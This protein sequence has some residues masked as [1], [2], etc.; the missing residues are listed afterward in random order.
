VEQNLTWR[1]ED[2]TSHVNYTDPG[3]FRE[4]F[5]FAARRRVKQE[6]QVQFTFTESATIAT[7]AVTYEEA[8]EVCTCAP[9]TAG[10]ALL[11]ILINDH[12][13]ILTGEAVI[14]CT[15]RVCCLHIS[16]AYTSLSRGPHFRSQPPGSTPEQLGKST[17]QR[18]S[19]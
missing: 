3:L 7:L 4:H 11:R 17:L 6:S 19:V 10:N 8:S 15:V 2:K 12:L 18:L 14:T 5:K 1:G 13:T 16:H 9:T